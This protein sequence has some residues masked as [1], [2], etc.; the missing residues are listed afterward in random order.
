MVLRKVVGLAAALALCASGVAAQTV[1]NGETM[2]NIDAPENVGDWLSYSRGWDEQRFSPL[3]AINDSNVQNLGLAWYA[4]LTE[5][6]QWQTTPVMVD[7]RIYVTTPW[8]K[9][10]AFDAASGK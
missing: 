3:D 1:V 7:G 8:S 4:D 5:R 6:G 2:R 9:V 10:Y